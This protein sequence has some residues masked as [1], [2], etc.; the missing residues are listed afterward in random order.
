MKIKQDIF[1]NKLMNHINNDCQTFIQIEHYY[2]LVNMNQ[3]KTLFTV[4]KTIFYSNA[5]N[6]YV[7]NYVFLLCFR[8]C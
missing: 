6:N 2:L 3:T 4:N 1:F 8:M 7:G 5:K